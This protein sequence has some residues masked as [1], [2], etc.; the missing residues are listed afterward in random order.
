MKNHKLINGQLLQ[1]NKKFS[2][3]KQAQKEKIA[4]W[5][6]EAY[7]RYCVVNSRTPNK[8]G[9]AE[10]IRD[11]LQKLTEQSIWLPESEI[12]SYYQSKKNHLRER[13]EK[14]AMNT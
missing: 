1:M 9:D 3:L 2:H 13:L 4:E 12:W 5:L 6:Y 8:E 11:V 14:A 10:I 7:R